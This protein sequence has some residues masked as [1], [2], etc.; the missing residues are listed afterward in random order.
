V[1]FLSLT[2]RTVISS[3]MRVCSALTGLWEI[4]A[5]AVI[6]GSI[7]ELKVARPSL[8]AFGS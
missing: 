6:V 5:W 3:I 4:E 1:R 8:L 7:L 2:P